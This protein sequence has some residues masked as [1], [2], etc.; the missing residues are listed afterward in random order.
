[1]NK[2]VLQ[3][4]GQFQLAYRGG[5][6]CDNATNSL[7][8][9]ERQVFLSGTYRIK[10]IG[11]QATEPWI[12]DNDQNQSATS[13]NKGFPLLLITSPQFMQTLV[14]DLPGPV[15]QWGTNF[16]FSPIYSTNVEG[17]C[18]THSNC[19]AGDIFATDYVTL[20]HNRIQLQIRCNDTLQTT[21]IPAAG[22]S[23]VFTKTLRDAF[24]PSFQL[25]SFIFTFYFE[26]I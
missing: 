5:E 10:L 11:V 14:P 4:K 2:Q 16:Q 22:T 1:M 24:G 12:S 26:K 7:L 18:L 19:I 15:V 21:M 9:P 3:E 13:P 25:M 8:L 6:F 20:I 17:A 23:S